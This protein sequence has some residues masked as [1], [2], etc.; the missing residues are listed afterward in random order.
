MID[1]MIPVYKPDERFF[2]L[3]DML[4]R[5]TVKI[6]QIILMNTEQKYWDEWIITIRS[7]SFRMM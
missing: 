3:L 2:E 5:Q 1:V 6:N 4:G 7:I